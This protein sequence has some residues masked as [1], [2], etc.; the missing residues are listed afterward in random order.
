M[1]LLDRNTEAR[2]TRLKVRS[3][4]LQSIFGDVELAFATIEH[5][6]R[7]DADR[8]SPQHTI[9]GSKWLEG[10]I[11]SRHQIASNAF[12][13]G[14]SRPAFARASASSRCVRK[15]AARSGPTCRSRCAMSVE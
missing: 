10:I 1:I 13:Y 11:L 6:S 8:L 2:Q 3:D 15:R 14:V 9:E 12:S 5:A 4:G 7:H